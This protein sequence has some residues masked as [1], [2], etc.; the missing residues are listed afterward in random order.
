MR[1]ILI[2]GAAA[3][4]SLCLTA[5]PKDNEPVTSSE[6]ADSLD[7]STLTAQASELTS[8]SVEIATNFTIGGAVANAVAELRTFI[9]TQLPCA[10]ITLTQDSLSITYGAKPGVCVYRGHVYSGQHLITVVK[11]D[12]NDVE[13]DH[14]WTKLSNGILQVSGTAQVTWSS[15]AST[16][17]VKHDLTWTRMADARTGHGTGDETQKSL[18][19]GLG[20]GFGVDG[21]RTWDGKTG[22]YSLGAS[23]IEWRWSDP[24]PQ[25]GTWVL[26]TPSDKI[27]SLAFARV[28]DTRIKVTFTSGDRKYAFV[29]AQTGQITGG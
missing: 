1:P 23:A 8:S 26:V 22:H 24:V 21:S 19:G 28:D 10:A 29:I 3:S 5:C 9:A 12:T 16:R 15:S 20:E 25:A 18:S 27:V 11:N 7:E 4:L 6:A 2:L 14:R 17:R 13:V